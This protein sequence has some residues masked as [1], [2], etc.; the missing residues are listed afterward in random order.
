MR[1]LKVICEIASLIVRKNEQTESMYYG[2][3]YLVRVRL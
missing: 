1:Q 2:E 3:F